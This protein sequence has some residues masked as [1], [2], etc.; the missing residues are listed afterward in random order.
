MT[1]LVAFALRTIVV[2]LVTDRIVVYSGALEEP[3]APLTTMFFPTSPAVKFA[4]ADVSVAVLLVIA[5]SP[6]SCPS[7]T[8]P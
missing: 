1:V 2:E 7:P 5:A 6:T 8:A 3:S 4:V